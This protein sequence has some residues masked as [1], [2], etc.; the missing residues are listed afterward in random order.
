L[1]KL[2]KHELFVGLL[3]IAVLFLICLARI[4]VVAKN[5]YEE[6]IG[7]ETAMAQTSLELMA[8]R[9]PVPTLKPIITASPTSTISPT[10]IPTHI[11][12]LPPMDNIPAPT[13]YDCVETVK[14]TCIKST[15]N[16]IDSIAST[17]YME[18]AGTDLHIGADIMQVL[19]NTMYNA[20]NCWAIGG[21]SEEWTGL[22]PRHILYSQISIDAKWRLALYILSR[23]YTTGRNTYPAW[24]AWEVPLPSK[25]IND[26]KYY[27]DIWQAVKDAVELWLVSGKIHIILP[28]EGFTEKPPYQKIVGTYNY[29]PADALRANRGIMYF[30]GM[31]GPIDLTMA[32]NASYRYD[33]T[34][35]G[36]EHHIYYSTYGQVPGR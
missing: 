25:T 31:T 12:P 36:I 22:N 32:G 29:Y 11:T 16:F 3:I 24:N 23:P 13:Y 21:C 8:T 17:L 20:W 27:S 18:G 2:L 1:N 15:T 5:S 34:M 10:V 9:T 14:T 28:Y 7:W 33:F 35:K 30:Y 19:D 6:H 26:I 4:A